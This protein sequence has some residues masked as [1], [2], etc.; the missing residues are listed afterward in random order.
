MRYMVRNVEGGEYGPF[1][2]EELRQLV[3]QQRLGPGDFVRREQGNTWNPFEKIEG[4]AS[5]LSGDSGADG[6]QPFADSAAPSD[7]RARR[8]GAPTPPRPAASP[9]ELHF[10]A[11]GMPVASAAGASFGDLG[12]PDPMNPMAP[13]AVAPSVKVNPFP[14]AGLPIVLAENEDVQFVLVQS[15]LDA[16]R[17]SLLSTVL[18]YRGRM[19]CTDRR[20]VTIM[21]GLG[22]VSMSIVWNDRAGSAGIRSHTNIIR[23]LLGGILTI[24]GGFGLLGVVLGLNALPIDATLMISAV[25]G[26]MAAVGGLLLLTSFAKVV[27]VGDSSDGIVFPCAAASPWHLAK[28]DEAR[29]RMV[30]KP[31]NA[32]GT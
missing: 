3:R 1:T 31:G 27:L 16:C 2:S 17:T 13:M 19:I 30:T 5:L 14:A 24:V 25:Y 32:G 21:P 28:I 6:A 11:P 10:D 7:P 9:E 26:V 12:T 23:A 15:T 8:S 18:G 20:T 29:M 4:L 22:R